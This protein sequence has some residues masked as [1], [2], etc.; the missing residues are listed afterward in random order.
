MKLHLSLPL[1]AA[2][3]TCMVC[4]ATASADTFLAEGVSY[5]N[6]ASS[7]RF[8]D[9]DKGANWNNSLIITEARKMYSAANYDMSVFGDLAPAITTPEYTYLSSTHFSALTNDSG[10]CWAYTA[11]NMLQYW[12]TYYGVFAKQA[13]SEGTSIVHGLNY[14]RE[15]MSKL[16]GTQ[17]LKLNKLFYDSFTNTGA[18]PSK[19]FNWYLKGINGA[20]QTDDSSA[21]GYFAQYFGDQSASTYVNFYPNYSGSRTLSEISA[22]ML[23]SLGYTQNSEGAW[24]QTTKGQ[25]MHLDLAGNSSH[26]ITCY[27]IELNENG[28]LAALYVVNSDDGTYNLEKVYCQ[29]LSNGVGLYYDEDC[30]QAW[31]S[32]FRVTGWSSI[33]TPEVLKN[34]LA[35][36]ESGNL[37][38]M[39]NLES[40]TNT[41]AAADVNV[42]PTDETGWMVYAGTDTEHA[43]Y[44]NSYYAAGRGVE[45]NDTAAATNVNVGEDISVASMAVNNSEKDYTFSGEGQ[46][47]TT[48]SLSKTGTGALVFDG[49]KL[50]AQGAV[51][52]NGGTITFTTDASMQS[53]DT[54]SLTITGGTTEIRNSESW[55]NLK[56]VEISEEAKL[57]VGASVSVAENITTATTATGALAEGTEAGIYATYC[58]TVGTEGDSSTGNVAL[59]GNMSAGSYIH[60]QGNADISGNLSSNG[61]SWGT[62]D[63]H[64]TIGGKA[65]IG[66]DLSAKQYVTIGGDATVGGKVEVTTDLSVG[67]NATLNGDTTVGGK[68]T[69]KGD[70]AGGANGTNVTAASAELGGNVSDVNL[71]ADSVMVASGV[72]LDSVN[73]ELSGSELSLDN[74][75]VTGNSGFK[76]TSGN[77]TL[78][79][80]NV[81]FVFDASNSTGQA[82]Q[83]FTLMA[84]DDT[85]PAGTFYIDSA[86]LEGINVSGSLTLDLSYWA[87]EIAQGGYSD[88]VLT[89]ADDMVFSDSAAVQASLDGTNFVNATYTGENI[90]QFSVPQLVNAIPEPTTATLSLL[91]LAALA[92]RRRRR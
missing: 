74:V 90:A 62:A 3:L 34:M 18:D 38:W 45:F 2:L 31:R 44:Y 82:V 32:N 83:A 87:D 33:T 8:Y 76:S 16:A 24:E 19:A 47:I 11:A 14:D 60:I 52:A 12:Q 64:I 80:N 78:N 7:T 68:L 20:N 43:G 86:M 36:Y 26:A 81:T 42:L 13:M 67:G 79:A 5:D 92:A 15:Y 9:G 53:V 55:T 23:E 6:L 65:N 58:I 63:S 66:G 28:E 57:T 91:A 29:L 46:T 10:H 73:M 17:S 40:W 61:T 37:T 49:V 35:E 72:T 71:K 21:P 41:A 50:Y 1:R 69:V 56:S 85:T 75:V 25:I 48:G 54:S 51:T 4:A 59:A 77:L 88:V 30:T 84:L 89:F 27:G 22:L 39:G 70:L